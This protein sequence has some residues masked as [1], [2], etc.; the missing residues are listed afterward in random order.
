MPASKGRSKQSHLSLLSWKLTS[1]S[2]QFDPARTLLCRWPLRQHVC[3]KNSTVEGAWL[4]HISITLWKWHTFP[5]KMGKSSSHLRGKKENTMTVIFA[6]HASARNMSCE[7]RRGGLFIS[8]ITRSHA[9]LHF[10]TR[11]CDALLANNRIMYLCS[12]N[13]FMNKYLLSKICKNVS[14]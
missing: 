2:E 3:G 6:A 8:Y 11:N 13:R 10:K 14:K 12:P 9:G 5:G 7:G 1:A 4:R